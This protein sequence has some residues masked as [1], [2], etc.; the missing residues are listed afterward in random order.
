MTSMHVFVRGSTVVLLIGDLSIFLGS[1]VLTLLVRYRQIPSSEIVDQH[2]VPFLIL[3]T[4]WSLVFV[5]TGLYDRK[6][7]FARKQIPGVVLRAQIINILVAGIF[8]FLF[9]WG[10]APKTN[11]LIYLVISSFLITVWRLYIFPLIVTGK[12]M[13]VLIL[14]D[15]DE[16]LAVA[17]VFV[18]NPY[19]KN[20]QAFTLGSRD[21]TDIHELRASLLRFAE[22]KKIDV[23]IADMQDSRIEQLSKDFYSLVFA[24]KDIQF[25]NLPAIYE[26]LY[27]RI[28]PSLIGEVWFL[29]NVTTGSPHYAY[30]FLKRS[31]DILGALLLLVPFLIIFPAVAMLIKI[32]DGGVVLYKTKRSGQFNRPVDILKFRTM[33]GTDDGMTTVNTTLQV[34]RLGNILRKSRIDELPQL[35]NVLRG[36]LSFI[37][38]RP[39]FPARAAVY[40]EQIPYYNL[41]HLVK[42]GLSGWAQI[43][44]YDV[45]RGEIDTE[46]T[47]EKLSFDLYY[48]KHHSLL[49]DIEITLKTINTLLMRT[50]T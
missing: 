38:P 20:V 16:S 50:G 47:I 42:P 7:A 8:F 19:F 34:T 39:D 45:P 6:V 33:T 5:I 24:E 12:T 17:R 4:V 30:D 26:Q 23:I 35:L 37:G 46:R 21:T 11:L 3:F 32:Q 40:A 41:R 9:P 28:P 18:S 48:L 44:N 15:S 2:L 31:I 43:N 36:D 25:F 10:I 13:R 14:G 49:L 1:L 22:D 29:E 27:H